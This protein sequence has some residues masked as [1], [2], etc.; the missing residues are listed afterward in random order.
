[1]KMFGFCSGGSIAIV[2]TETPA[3]FLTYNRRTAPG[4][5]GQI[6]LMEAARVAVPVTEFGKTLSP[7]MGR[8]I[9]GALQAAFG[10]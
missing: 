1:M 7:D 2:R 8:A 3:V 5:L 10:E 4:P 9:N 6:E